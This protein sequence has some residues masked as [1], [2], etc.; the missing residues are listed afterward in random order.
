MQIDDNLLQKIEQLNEKY[1]ASGQDMLS[2]LDGLLYTDYLKYWDYVQLDVLLNLQQPRTS[3]PDE[4]VFITY[5]Q[6]TELYFKLILHEIDQITQDIPTAAIFLD[7]LERCNRY[8]DALIH[9]FDVMSKG[10][11]PEQ[12]L[13]FRM[14]LL[15]SSGFQSVQF[16]LIE[17]KATRFT[18]LLNNPSFSPLPEGQF[19]DFFE[20]MYWQEGAVELATGKKTLTLQL[21]KKKYSKLLLETAEAYQYRNLEMMAE[22][23]SF[24]DENQQQKIQHALRYFDKAINVDWRLMHLKSAVRYLKADSKAIAAT[25]G[26]NW[27]KYLPPV[28]QKRIFF[29]KLWSESE[30]ANW[31]K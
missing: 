23:L 30:K 13:K 15:P 22:E 3:F 25:G 1:S 9:S 18:N 29:P 19:A 28:E 6:I 20:Q 7:K 11:Q 31:G 4:L 5:H 21:F 8:A 16:R 14:A 27:Q 10:M 24:D 26:T 2:Y 17:L 12:F